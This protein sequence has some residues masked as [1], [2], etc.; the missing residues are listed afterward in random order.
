[1]PSDDAKKAS[2]ILGLARAATGVNVAVEASQQPALMKLQPVATAAHNPR[3]II[4]ANHI[5]QAHF[6][7][8]VHY[9]NHIEISSVHKP[10]S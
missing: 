1:M 2:T 10:V 6:V 5:S 7:M 8:A 3:Q 4:L 9:S